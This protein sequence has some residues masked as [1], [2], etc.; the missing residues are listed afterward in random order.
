[1]KATHDFQTPRNIFEKLIRDY[2]HLDRLVSGDAMF[3]FVSTAYHFQEWIKNSPLKT[4]EPVKRLL[5]KTASHK[6]IKLCKDIVTAKKNYQVIIDDPSLPEGHEIDFTK[7]PSTFDKFSYEKG[8]KNF[9]FKVGDEEIDPFQFKEEILQL[10][11]TYFQ[12]K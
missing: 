2:E 9:V 12:V 11:S 5:R 3:N 8:D 6:Y 10:Y 1:M 4:S 7:F